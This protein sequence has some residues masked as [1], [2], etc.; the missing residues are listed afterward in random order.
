MKKIISAVLVVAMMFST[1]IMSVSAT[2]VYLDMNFESM[3]VFTERFVAGAF[4]V[5]EDEGL[6]Y[7]YAEA[8]ALQT[9]YVE[10]EGGWF[11]PDENV[12]MT[13][14]TTITLAVQDD[15]LS[16]TDRWI[17]L[18]Y[19]N[20]N[21]VYL[22]RET[23]RV[24]MSF[25]YD[26]ANKTFHFSR[27]WNN[28][29]EESQ[30]LDPVPMDIL[31]D[32]DEFFTLGM[33]VDKDHI[34][35]YYNDELIFDYYDTNMC[36]ASDIPA[37]FLFWQDGNFVQIKNITVADCG[38]IFEKTEPPV[39]TPDDADVTFAIEADD[40]AIGA[41]ELTA[42]LTVV[43]PEDATGYE[44]GG[45]KALIGYDSDVMTLAEEPT[46]EIS[47]TTMTS[48]ALTTDPYALV[49]LNTKP[50]VKAGTTVVA[51]L[52]FNLAEPAK[53]GNTYDITLALDENN[54]PMT[55]AS[56]DGAHVE[57]V[58]AASQIALINAQVG[59]AEFIYGDINDDGNVNLADATLL[60]KYL[61]SWDVTINA[62]AADVN[63]DDAIS[64]AD[65]TLLLKYLAGWDVVLGPA[66]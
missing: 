40:V 16:E 58:Y 2:E 12:W 36:I 46:W 50:T 3:E 8:K 20:D 14:D 48:P 62:A 45:F 56:E 61:A 51:T 10:D 37:P 25:S 7:G 59:V 41:T 33:S 17:N 47:G 39:P 18:V 53:A 9:A 66:A 55:L 43:L 13:F 60:L 27:G 42:D 28:V 49:W 21:L 31:V 38:H 19:C 30:L 65:A 57:T 11:L 24:M 23:A 4:Y 32:T 5:D 22:G 26:I 54:M 64:L 52:K 15:D 34:R 29:N 6:L 1:V 63:V 35:C 44:L